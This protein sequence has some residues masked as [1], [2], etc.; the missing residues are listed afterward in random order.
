MKGTLLFYGWLQKNFIGIDFVEADYLSGLGK[1]A[2]MA[3]N[4]AKACSLCVFIA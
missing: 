4:D 1:K 2:F 3:E